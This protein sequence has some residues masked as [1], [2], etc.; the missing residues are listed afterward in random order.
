MIDD[1]YVVD[2]ESHYPL[3]SDVMTHDSQV[4]YPAPRR[5]VA[6]RA[7]RPRPQP[8]VVK[9]SCEPL[10]SDTQLLIILFVMLIIISIINLKM[11]LELKAYMRLLREHF[12]ARGAGPI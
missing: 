2:T 7:P 4:S 8:P 5:P 12:V 10:L 9:P 11:S 1:Q 6:R 3:F